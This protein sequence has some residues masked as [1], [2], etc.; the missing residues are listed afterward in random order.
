MDA[1]VTVHALLT[2]GPGQNI[3]VYFCL[4]RLYLSEYPDYHSPAIEYSY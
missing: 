4:R 3:V 2:H 1:P